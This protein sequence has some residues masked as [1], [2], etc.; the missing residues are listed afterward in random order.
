MDSKIKISLNIKLI[1]ESSIEIRPVGINKAVA[2]FPNAVFYICNNGFVFEKN[3]YYIKYSHYRLIIPSYLDK[4]NN[5]VSQ[6]FLFLDDRTRYDYLKK[7]KNDL[8]ELSGSGV[9]G[10]NPNCRILIYN[11]YWFVY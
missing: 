3:Y 10:K 9:F 5:D 6:T 2:E 4:N 8:I 7:L 11:N 1:G